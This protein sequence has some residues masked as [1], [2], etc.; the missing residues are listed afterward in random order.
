MTK[1]IGLN[2]KEAE[3]AVKNDS[4]TLHRIVRELTGTSNTSRTRQARPY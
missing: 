1:G 2:T 3:A 4:K